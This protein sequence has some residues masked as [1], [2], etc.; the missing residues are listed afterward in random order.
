MEYHSTL[1]RK[2]ILTRTTWINPEDIMLKEINQSQKDK[3]YMNLFELSRIIQV[4]ETE[5]GMMVSKGSG[6]GEIEHCRLMSVEFQI[7]KTKKF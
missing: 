7:C 4:L 2:E 5:N 1:K 3:S 6:A